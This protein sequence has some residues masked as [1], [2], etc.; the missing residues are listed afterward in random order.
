MVLGHCKD[1][2]EAYIKRAQYKT[3]FVFVTGYTKFIYIRVC[4]CPSPGDVCNRS[5]LW[6]L[7]VLFKQSGAIFDF[8]EI[9]T[10]SFIFRLLVSFVNSYVHL[11]ISTLFLMSCL[12]SKWCLRNKVFF[13]QKCKSTIIIKSLQQ[14]IGIQCHQ[15]N[16]TYFFCSVIRW[17]LNSTSLDNYSEFSVPPS[18]SFSQVFCFSI[19]RFVK[20]RNTCY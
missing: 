9:A 12:F 16:V 15:M 11:L 10:V 19:L 14:V 18:R 3:R 5:S 17:E 6:R 4:L 8:V 13:L 7:V 2:S 20:F 1:S